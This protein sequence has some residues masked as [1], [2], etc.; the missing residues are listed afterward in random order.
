MSTE[1][2]QN[3]QNS[4]DLLGITIETKPYPQIL[5]NFTAL[6]VTVGEIGFQRLL[7]SEFYKINISKIQKYIWDLP[8]TS[9]DKI[10]YIN[11]REKFPDSSDIIPKFPHAECNQGMTV[12][13]KKIEFYQKHYYDF[14]IDPKEYQFLLQMIQVAS[15]GK[16]ILPRYYS[17]ILYSH[18]LG[19]QILERWLID[20][21]PYDLEFLKKELD[22][23]LIQDLTRI[24]LEY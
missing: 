18:P 22:P 20:K 12:D 1:V 10:F 19:G 16:I 13:Y 23:F 24:V 9:K 17:F 2:E 14:N 7:D 8:N 6:S 4:E 11:R 21:T 15:G 3:Y 5:D